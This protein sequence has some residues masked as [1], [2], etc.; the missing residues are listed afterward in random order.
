VTGD[1]VDRE[2]DTPRAHDAVELFVDGRVTRHDYFVFGAD[3]VSRRSPIVHC[4][5]DSARG[6]TTVTPSDGMKCD[7]QSVVGV[8]CFM[9][10]G[11]RSW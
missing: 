2:V 5:S 1:W 3:D 10:W 8:S 11:T 4:G 7:G 6:V 9:K